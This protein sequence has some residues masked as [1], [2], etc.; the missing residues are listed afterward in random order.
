MAEVSTREVWL[1]QSTRPQGARRILTLPDTD[2]VG[3]NPRARRGR[4]RK[5]SEV[6]LTAHGFNP[7]ARR[8]RDEVFTANQMYIKVSIHAPAGGATG[9]Y[10][11]AHRGSLFQSTR[12]QGARPV[13]ILSVNVLS[14]FQST[15]PQGARPYGPDLR[16]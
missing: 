15:R 9:G 13:F 14:K 5:P 4:D 7:R 16:R 2:T 11:L 6:W 12:P 3:F 10:I 8:G 1:F